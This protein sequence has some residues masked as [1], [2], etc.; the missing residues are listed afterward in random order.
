MAKQY[1]LADNAFASNFD[2]SFVGA[3]VFDRRVC[4]QAVDA[5]S[6]WGCDGGQKDTVQTLTEQRTYGSAIVACFDNPTIAT[7]PTPPA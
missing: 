3:P 2:G 4:E 7:K 1:V 5:R 6:H